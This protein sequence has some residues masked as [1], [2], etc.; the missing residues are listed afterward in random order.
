MTRDEI[1]ALMERR[2][3]AWDARDAARSGRDAR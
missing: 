3:A 2:A 1:L